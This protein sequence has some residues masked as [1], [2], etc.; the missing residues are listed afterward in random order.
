[1]IHSQKFREQLLLF[2]IVIST[3][4][5]LHSQVVIGGVDAADGAMLQLD[6][7]DKGFMIPRV[8]LTGRDDHTTITGVEPE[9]LWVYNTADSGIGENRVNEGFYFYDGTEWVRLYNEGYTR[10]FE[11]TSAVRSA[12][13]SFT[14]IIPG[15]NQTIVAPY[16]G[17]YQVH[18][19]AYYA[20]P[21][22]RFSSRKALGYGSVMLYVDGTKVS[23]SFI[24]SISKTTPGAFRALGEQTT[25]IHNV[26]MVEGQSYN[27]FAA[28][29]E[30]RQVNQ[31]TRDLDF[32]VNGNYGIWGIRTD[33]YEGGL[34]TIDN[35][36]N[37]YMTVTLLRQY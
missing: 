10:Q 11:Q 16:T 1:M 17:L 8:A 25:I 36:Q 3:S 22:G 6:S 12:N 21:Y 14:Y 2:V 29:R 18:I 24:Q 33:V 9:G 19:T 15:L 5:T 7:E 30:W 37:A 4:L 26:D 35:A 32:I 13:Q 28:V 27:L 20:A 23:E 34:P 31:D